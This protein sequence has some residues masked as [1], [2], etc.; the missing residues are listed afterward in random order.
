[1]CNGAYA[2]A[3]RGCL[4]S[5]RTS[6]RRWRVDSEILEGD[7]ARPGE[8]HLPGAGD[9]RSQRRKAQGGPPGAQRAACRGPGGLEQRASSR[10]ATTS[11]GDYSEKPGTENE[12][13]AMSQ[14]LLMEAVY[15]AVPRTGISPSCSQ[16]QPSGAIAGVLEACE[17]AQVMRSVWEESHGVV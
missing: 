9:Q 2:A 14:Q 5:A 12:V 7:L 17:V 16:K 8:D 4:S 10:A 6:P 13:T 11:L 15:R 1:M 3:G